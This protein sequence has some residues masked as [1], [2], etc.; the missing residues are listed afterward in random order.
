MLL[1]LFHTEDINNY[2]KQLSIRKR[3]I[4]L[5]LVF[6]KTLTNKWFI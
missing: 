4:I 1:C 6:L 5:I 3:D 2:A